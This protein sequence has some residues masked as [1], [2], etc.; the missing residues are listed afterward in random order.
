MN[1][2]Q[3]EALREVLRSGA[4]ETI[5]YGVQSVAAFNHG[6]NA[7]MEKVWNKFE[8]ALKELPEETEHA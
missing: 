2:K 5:G 7:A 4:P 6:W 8:T 1:K 3:L